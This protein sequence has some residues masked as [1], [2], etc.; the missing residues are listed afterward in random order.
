MPL[1][2]LYVFKLFMMMMMMIDDDDRDRGGD[3]RV[4]TVHDDDDDGD[5]RDRGGDVGKC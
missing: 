2:I 4:Q 5:D 3:V 1:V